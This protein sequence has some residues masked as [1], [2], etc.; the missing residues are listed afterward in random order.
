MIRFSAALVVAGLALLLAGAITGQLSLIY[1]AIAVGVCAALVLVAGLIAGRHEFFGGS[2]A[3][4]AGARV[5][6]TLASLGDAAS[7][8]ALWDRTAASTPLVPAGRADPSQAGLGW[9]SG[10]S[11]ADDLWARVDAE[12]AAAGTAT[13][14]PKLTKDSATEEV[15]GRVEQELVSPANWDSRLVIPAAT[16]EPAAEVASPAEPGLADWGEQGGWSDGTWPEGITWSQGSDLPQRIR[17][18]ESS[19]ASAPAVISGQVWADADDAAANGATAGETARQAH[20]GTEADRD[21]AAEDPAAFAEGESA[22]DPAAS[23]EGE[24]AEDP[25]VSADGRTAEVT[26]V[27]QDWARDEAGAAD[28]PD[29]A[30][31]ESIA[32]GEAAAGGADTPGRSGAP[33]GDPVTGGIGTSGGEKPDAADTSAANV[34][35]AADHADGGP[36]ITAAPEPAG[37]SGTSALQTPARS[38]AAPDPGT[39]SAPG[40]PP[41]SDPQSGSDTASA[42]GTPPASGTLSDPNG[43]GTPPDPNGT[44]GSYMPAPPVVAALPDAGDP[45]TQAF[46]PVSAGPA[47]AGPLPVRPPAPGAPRIE[48]PGLA[49]QG[50]DLAH[51]VVVPGVPRYHYPECI[52]I[53]FLGADDIARVSH[54]AAEA[55]GC[56]PCRACQPDKPLAGAGGYAEG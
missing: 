51:V 28:D 47:P 12:L 45:G 10:E 5:P 11:P 23:A 16:G 44:S 48:Q 53:R 40:T 56:V 34:T 19:G 2:A 21:P 35:P 50:S 25:A 46:T 30:R 39:P 33:D 32:A 20:G 41:A 15:W 7:A 52:L 17:P 43:L 18:Q 54:V 8:G 6:G 38:D 26:A 3:D 36:G 22:E 31:A 9:P 27:D 49:G 37:P 1:A 13:R 4:A 42:P 29:P 14:A 24:S 55:A